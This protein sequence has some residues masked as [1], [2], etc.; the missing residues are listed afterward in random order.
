MPKPVKAAKAPSKA[1]K[2]KAA[3]AKT[4]AS[5]APDAAGKGKTAGLPAPPVAQPPQDFPRGGAPELTP[6]EYREVADRVKEDLFATDAAAGD[7]DMD[8]D[9]G[10]AAAAPAPQKRPKKRAAAALDSAESAKKSKVDSSA[11]GVSLLTYKRLEVGMC[12]VGFVKEINALDMSISLPNQLTGFVA[13]TEVS[14]HISKMVELAVADSDDEKDDSDDENG[15]GAAKDDDLKLP[16]LSDYFVIGQPVICKI[17]SLGQASAAAA[18]ENDQ[19]DTAAA[20]KKRIDLTLK[21]D[22]VNAD[23]AKDDLVAGMVLPVQIGSKQDHGYVVSLGVDGTSGFLRNDQ[24]KA[25]LEARGIQEIPA[26]S[27]LQASI[28][29]ASP[30]ARAIRISLDPERIASTTMAHSETTQLSH[31]R[32]GT[33][34]SAKIEDVLENGVAVS[35]FKF[36]KGTIDWFHLPDQKILGA[37]HLRS[38]FKAGQKIK[39]RVLYIDLKRK[40]LGLTLSPTLLSWQAPSFD[41]LEIG[42]ISQTV[43]VVRVDPGLGLLVQ[44]SDSKLGYVHISRLAD[45]H[46]TKIDKKFRAGTEHPGRVIGFDFCDNLLILSFEPKILSQPFLRLTDIKVGTEI[47]GQ[48]VRILPAGVI[49]AVSDSI[50]GLCPTRHMSDATITH[51]EKLF[52]EGSTAKFH[53]LAIDAANKRLLLTHKK[54]LMGSKLPP[55]VS[56]ADATVGMITTGIISAVKSFGCIVTFYNHVR[57]LVPISELSDTFVKTPSDLFR[58]G[59]AVK[60]RI[61]SVD[62]AEDKMRASFKLTPPQGKAASAAASS[63]APALAPGTLVRATVVA[64]TDV[65]LVVQVKGAGQASIAKAHLSDFATHAQKLFDTLDTGAVL[66]DALVYATDRRGAPLLTKKASLVAQAK[67]DGVKTFADLSEGDILAG[68]VRHI[69]EKSCFVEFPGGLVGLASVHNIADHFVASIADVLQVGQ[70]VLALVTK[71]ESETSR[72][73]LSL[74]ASQLAGSPAYRALETER[75][76][77]LLSGRSLAARDA[78]ADRGVVL[79][80]TIQGTVEKTIPYGHLVRLE[81]GGSGLLARA[82]KDLPVGTAVRCR[83]LDYDIET[84]IADLGHAADDLPKASLGDHLAAAQVAL[85]ANQTLEAHVELVKDQYAV[86]S[87]PKLKHALVFC[88]VRGPNSLSGPF[89]RF[90][91]GDRTQV[92]IASVPTFVKAAPV[93]QQR[94]L[95]LPA[96]PET[97]PAAKDFGSKR[98]IKN[99]ID[100]AIASLDDVKIGMIVKGTVRSV[101]ETQVNVR[102]ADNLN[103]RIHGSEVYDGVD[104]IADPAAP[105]AGVFKPGMLVSAKV[106]GFHDTKTHSFLPI[107]HTH[108]ASSIVVDLTVRPS[109]M[110]LP[111]Y[112]LVADSDARRPTLAT[113]GVGSEHIGLIQSIDAQYLRV[114]IGGGLLGTVAALDASADLDVVR[115]LSAHFAVGQAV[116]CFVTGKNEAKRVIQLSLIARV[117]QAASDRRPGQ[118]VNAMVSKVDP[119]RGLQLLLS[120]HVQ[121]RVHLTDLADEP[122]KAPTAQFSE[123]NCVRAVVLEVHQDTQRVSCSLR[124]S[125]VADAADSAEAATAPKELEFGDI[126]ADQ[127]VAGYVRDISE[128][129]CFVSL[130]RGIHARVKMSELA[131]EYV[132]DIKAAF[133]PGQLVRGRVLGVDAGKRQIELSLKP[134]VV[135]VRGKHMVQFGDLAVGMKMSGTVKRIQ[136]FG[137]F[138]Q[139]HNSALTGLCHMSEV[140]D[141]PVQNLERLYSVGDAVKAVVLRLDKAKQRISLGLKA[142]YFDEGDAESGGDEDD[143]DEEMASADGDEDAAATDD[144]EDED[145]VIEGEEIV[146]ASDEDVEP[147]SDDDEDADDDDDDDEDA[148]D[149]EGDFVEMDDDAEGSGD[150]DADGDASMAQAAGLVAPLAIDGF[151]WNSQESMDVAN[152]NASGS[153]EASGS[154]DGDDEDDDADGKK[155]KRSRRAKKRAK[156]EEEKRIEREELALVEGDHPPEVA[157]DYERL[158]LGSPNNSYLWIK[159]MVFHLQMAE[160]DKGR[161]VA[162]RALKSINFREEQERLNVWVAYLNLENT[163][164]TAETLAKVF[165][166]AAQMNDAK[167]IYIHMAK[168]YER[169]GKVDA[170]TALYQ[171]MCKKF[172]ESSQVW[173]DYAQFLM[174]HGKPDA[175]RQLLARS[176]QSLPKRKHIEATSKFAQM[177]FKLGEPERGRTVFEGLMSTCPKRADLWSIYLDMEIRAADRAV[178]RRLFERV[179]ALKWSAKKM[180]FFF[181]KYLDFE[182]KHGDAHGVEHVKQA[183]MRFVE[184]L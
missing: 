38:E 4:A 53:V 3:K 31:I 103:G 8:A 110:A 174:K 153:D 61:L 133:K 16:S 138:I 29:D 175:A 66:T 26:G 57:A 69:H 131:D 58:V 155:S 164:G 105:L 169:T 5:S 121:A 98:A 183:A 136:P 73:T 88:L 54:S 143:D 80:M 118:A 34:V 94:I 168:I 161:Q 18:K 36:F 40:V 41:G 10:A 123:G 33:L 76:A 109:E 113:L 45:T 89:V 149:G 12:V 9:D 11:L 163:Y 86:L 108:S 65:A 44:F 173:M 157:E 35:V 51:P 21:P 92:Q 28:L 63:D 93:A 176:L 117:V 112:E 52:R 154:D 55:L 148:D 64:K 139:L 165:E 78:T 97:P 30:T 100:S 95:A 6:L 43:R 171:T 158:L 82:S 50:H 125:H 141:K 172:K 162:E 167:S 102:L 71:L 122:A 116:R 70:S 151:S 166:R 146:F 24:A 140:A 126:E 14:E 85:K 37:E 87:V 1:A 124:K 106:V 2:A 115:D 23:L 68:F 111:A 47:K 15:D 156:A 32:P 90:K 114:V 159:Y 46:T 83:V 48:I 99:P 145:E 39:P 184:S 49:V 84:K 20:K 72:I 17:L 77:A 152:E 179:L 96:K 177:E 74:K 7:V 132:V 42:A 128:K 130:S 142:S 134:S 60:C 19:T 59:Q 120:N 135:G 147:E 56:Y 91:V 101:K 127:I 22:A 81:S 27:V 67:R 75:L 107:S 178:I 181:K 79:G 129:G 25:Y 182:K 104:A 13:L 160:V 62:P 137:L 144:D 180:K 150:D 170:C 119:A